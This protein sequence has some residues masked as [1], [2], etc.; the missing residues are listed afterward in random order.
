MNKC[1]A[2]LILAWSTIALGQKDSINYTIDV[3]VLN[4]KLAPLCSIGN[5]C[6]DQLLLKV[7][8]G[9]D[10]FELAG[11]GLPD[12]FLIRPGTYKA[13]FVRNDSPNSYQNRCVYE[14]QFPDGKTGKFDVVAVG[15][16]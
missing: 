11:W 9:S 12:R 14:I 8:I 6:H 13:R 15:D 7:N 2:V 3:Q 4:S 16:I 5:E 1:L 10:K